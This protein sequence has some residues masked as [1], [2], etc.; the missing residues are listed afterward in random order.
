MYIFKGLG[1]DLICSVPSRQSLRH[2]VTHWR[3]L[4]FVYPLRFFLS[5]YWICEQN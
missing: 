1:R 4:S 5:L 3:D 2:N